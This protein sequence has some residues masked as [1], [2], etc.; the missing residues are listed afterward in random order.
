MSSVQIDIL[1]SAKPI[2]KLGIRRVR[3]VAEGFV[4]GASAAAQGHAI[5]NFVGLAIGAD[6]RYECI[7]VS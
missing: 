4:L 3:S 7:G 1:G 6:E 5:A 2:A